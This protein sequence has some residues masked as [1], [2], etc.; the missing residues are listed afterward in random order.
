MRLQSLDSAT[1]KV[2]Y[3]IV[4]LWIYCLFV[5]KHGLRILPQLRERKHPFGNLKSCLEDFQVHPLKWPWLGYCAGAQYARRLSCSTW[6]TISCHQCP[7]SIKIDVNMW[8]KELSMLTT[9]FWVF[10]LGWGQVLGFFFVKGLSTSNFDSFLRFTV[11]KGD[12]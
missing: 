3:L 4:P 9:Y 12:P 7:W 2:T 1:M 8:G 10:R 6:R 5:R 11:K